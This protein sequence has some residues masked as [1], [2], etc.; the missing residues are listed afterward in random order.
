MSPRCSQE[1]LPVRSAIA[2]HAREPWLWMPHVCRVKQS[3]PALR[4]ARRPEDSI[5]LSE[6]V[7]PLLSRETED[8]WTKDKTSTQRR[9]LKQLRRWQPKRKRS[10]TQWCRPTTTSTSRW[11]PR[12]GRKLGVWRRHASSKSTGSERRRR[13][14]EPA[15]P[16][17]TKCTPTW[18][19]RTS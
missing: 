2:L 6:Q 19:T 16:T 11:C 10:S 12:R 1:H 9:K 18:T 13:R 3:H 15:T 8:L 14:K 5:T 7:A 17:G 4:H